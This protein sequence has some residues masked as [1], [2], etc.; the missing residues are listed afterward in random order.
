MIDTPRRLMRTLLLPMIAAL[1]M[2]GPAAASAQS[3]EPDPLNQT[4][5]SNQSQATGQVGVNSTRSSCGST[6]HRY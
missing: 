3:I 6:T 2:A 4:I 1:L 5:D